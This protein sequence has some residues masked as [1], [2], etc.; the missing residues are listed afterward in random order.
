MDA[1][2]EIRAL[3]IVHAAERFDV[4]QLLAEHGLQL[5]R[6]VEYTAGVYRQGHLIATASL[7]GGVIKGVAVRPTHQGEG[8]TAK[9]VTYL[10]MEAHRRGINALF[11]FTKP[12]QS[13]AFRGIG[14]TVIARTPEVVLLESSRR[15]LRRYLHALSERA[16]QETVPKGEVAA[17]VVNAN[18][19][20]NGHRALIE[21]A[22]MACDR[23][24][25][26]VVEEDAS[27]VP[28]HDRLR[29][30]REGVGGSPLRNGARG[31]AIRHL[32]GY[33]SHLLHQRNADDKPRSR[34]RSP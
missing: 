8:L 18:P 22:T 10:T 34:S 25:L 5:D 19:F 15:N 16:V 7:A 32:A 33:L 3:S 12:D 2:Y 11:V 17:I 28:F 26:M 6:D 31:W 20:T 24:H 13:D 21:R 29:L 30:V 14:Y 27:L 23:V 9:L 1:D 4:E